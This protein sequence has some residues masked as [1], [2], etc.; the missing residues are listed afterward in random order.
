MI[1]QFELPEIPSRRPSRRPNLQSRIFP[2]CQNRRANEMGNSSCQDW[3][4]QNPSYQAWKTQWCRSKYKTS[5]KYTGVHPFMMLVPELQLAIAEH[6]SLTA[7]VSLKWTCRYFYKLISAQCLTIIKNK[8]H[9]HHGSEYSDSRS[10]TSDDHLLLG[11]LDDVPQSKKLD[12]RQAE[13][14]GIFQRANTLGCE[15]CC[16][17][18]PRT[19]FDNSQRFSIEVTTE[20]QQRGRRCIK[21]GGHG[22]W[23]SM[24]R[25]ELDEI[26]YVACLRKCRRL[27]RCL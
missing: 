8:A 5:A 12:V 6:L 22:I 24:E 3:D 14:W 13:R 21:N 1:Q 7:T 25:I 2:E 20:I 9:V 26:G 19:R 27:H 18:R 11:D 23:E 15:I 17:L 4:L 10:R 16:L